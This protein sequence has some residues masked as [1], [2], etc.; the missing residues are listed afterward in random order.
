MG[1][2]S[3]GRAEARE[4]NRLQNEMVDRLRSVELPDID[5]MRILLENPELLEDTPY[6]LGDSALE[7][8]QGDPAVLAAQEETLARLQE[9]AD[10]GITEG[11]IS[12]QRE[13]RDDAEAADVARQRSALQRLAERGQSD[14]LLEGL[15]RQDRAQRE[16]NRSAMTQDMM[17]QQA[18]Q[19]RQA[20]IPQAVQ[21]AQQMRGQELAEQTRL[22]QTR[23]ARAQANLGETQ[24]VQGMRQMYADQ[25]ADMR[26]QQ[27]M[28]NKGLLQQDFQNR[29]AKATGQ[30][31]AA[32]TLTQNALAQSQAASQARA[33]ALQGLTQMGTG[34]AGAVMDYNKSNSK[35]KDS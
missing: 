15:M 6:L 33:R 27:Q 18:A 17:I 10:T 9:I 29:M 23:D 5:K 7:D 12:A 24:R 19:A 35:G 8:V 32:N 1:S 20:A 30:S 28:Y 3:A 13:L 14:P 26:N 2:R 16:A 34:I 11:D 4:A 21:A 31:Q 25:A 22:A